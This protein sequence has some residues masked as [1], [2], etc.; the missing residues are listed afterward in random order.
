M[1]RASLANEIRPRLDR[2]QG[3]LLQL[4]ASSSAQ[5]RQKDCRGRFAKAAGVYAQQHGSDAVHAIALDRALASF[6]EK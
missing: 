2:L 1:P 6:C 3:Q 4:L 5:R